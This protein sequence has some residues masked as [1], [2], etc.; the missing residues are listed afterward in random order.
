MYNEDDNDD[1]KGLVG[2][3]LSTVIFSMVAII[4]ISSL[5]IPM[6]STVGDTTEHEYNSGVRIAKMDSDYLQKFVNPTEF[7]IDAIVLNSD[8]IGI[9]GTQ[10][11]DSR[12]VTIL[13]TSKMDM[14]YPVLI[15]TMDGDTYKGF[16]TYERTPSGYIMK[17]VAQ[18]STGSTFTITEESTQMGTEIYIQDPNGTMTLNNGDMKTEDPLY[19]DVWGFSVTTGR[20][21][22]AD[23]NRGTMITKSGDDPAQVWPSETVT[24]S[25]TTGND[26][27]TVNSIKYA[28]YTCTYYVGPIYVSYEE[29][30]IQGTPVGSM[31]GVI[32]LLIITGVILYVAKSM[33][34]DAR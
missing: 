26:Y 4:I 5:A 10:N 22:I 32:P 8:G 9:T 1:N 34:K 16:T 33:K 15:N 18:S 17:D 28:G 6:L 23:A 27:D 29:N 14:N 19:A 7:D 12:T 13:P 25:I 3:V 31:V 2:K 30:I 11:G 20:V 21:V 24:P